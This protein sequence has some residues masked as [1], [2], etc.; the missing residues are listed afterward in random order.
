MYPERLKIKKEPLH[1]VLKV[2]LQTWFRTL[3]KRRK[4]CYIAIYIFTLYV[5][6][7]FFSD[8]LRFFLLNHLL[9]VLRTFFSLFFPLRIALLARNSLSFSLSKTILLSSSFLK[10]IFTEYWILGW[11][12][13]FFQHLKN[14]PLSSGLHDFYAKSAIIQTIGRM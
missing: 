8:V 1:I 5:T 10:D 11:S 9:S 6:L 13:F 3:K 14:V 2:F 4:T 7:F 12:F